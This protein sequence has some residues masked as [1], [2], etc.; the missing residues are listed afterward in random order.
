MPAN[1][2]KHSSF[3]KTILFSES[4]KS[5]LIDFSKTKAFSTADGRGIQI[6][7]KNK[8]PE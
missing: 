2:I 8:Y 7:K 4:I 3:I 1:A 6:A 5:K